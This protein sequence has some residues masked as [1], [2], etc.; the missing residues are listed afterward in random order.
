VSDVNHPGI[1]NISE[2]SEKWRKP[3]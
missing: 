3:Y 2:L 1:G